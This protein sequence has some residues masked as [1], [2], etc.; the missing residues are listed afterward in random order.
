MT[1]TIG[2]LAC[3]LGMAHMS[4]AQEVLGL[5]RFASSESITSFQP[6]STTP[7]QR[8]SYNMTGETQRC[9]HSGWLLA[10]SRVSW[11]GW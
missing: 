10:V 5:E 11:G 4:H 8:F 2:I 6:D 3:L 9:A 7:S 1:K